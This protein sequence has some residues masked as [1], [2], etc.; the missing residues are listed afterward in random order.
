MPSDTHTEPVVAA[1]EV[2]AI[3][4]VEIAAPVVESVV[5]PAITETVAPEV[6]P[7]TDTPT[8]LS[9]PTEELAKP[10][11]PE[12]K[13]PA[14]AV[15]PITP[16]TEVAPVVEPVYEFKLPDNITVEQ[17]R[18][19]AY[20]SVLKE[21][22]IAPEVGQS[23][24][25]MHTAAMTDYAAHLR[26][27]QHTSFAETRANWA[28]EVRSDPELG[29][30]GHQTALKAAAR[31]RDLLVPEERREAFNNF[32]AVTGA[33]DHPEFIRMLYAAARI[34]DEPAAPSVTAMPS[35]SGQ[36]A[37]KTFRGIMYDHSSSRRA[38]G[39]N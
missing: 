19:D 28:N 18:L 24:I 38:A 8:L 4:A 5:A 27:E 31:V 34:F 7:H 11:E 22:K 17:P 20:T 29:G 15:T 10:T 25:E 30:S 32:L 26:Q 3:A 2:A 1:P 23:L 14:A 39:R 9:A 12:V 36:P 6:K 16:V 35:A 37:A 13:T 33:G 21:H